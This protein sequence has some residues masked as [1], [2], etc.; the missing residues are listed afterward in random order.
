VIYV[1]SGVVCVAL[2]AIG[3]VV[4]G[5][6]TTVFVIMASYLFARSCPAFDRWLQENRWFGPSLKAYKET[7]GMP[8]RAKAI[9]VASM[10]SGICVS[11]V[12]MQHAPLTAKLA[13]V[14]GGAIGTAVVT[15][16]V[17]TV[18]ALARRS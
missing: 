1:A 18:P 15:W 4:P 10:W 2:A 11:M 3:V 6:P 12:A 13:V 17:R 9:A 7:G 8:A 14:T 16:Y 5:M